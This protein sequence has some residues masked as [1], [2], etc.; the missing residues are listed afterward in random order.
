MNKLCFALFLFCQISLGQEITLNHNIGTNIIDQLNNFT[1][2]GGGVS[3]ARVFVLEEFGVTGEYTI[4][5]GSFAVQESGSA[6]G[7]GVIVNVYTIDKGFPDTFDESTI[8]GSS[9]LIDIPSFTN[10]AIFP[11]D[12]PVPIVV[13]NNVEM[14]L[15]EVRLGLQNQLVFMGGTMDSFDFSWWNPLNHQSCQGDP[16]T[17]ESTFDLSRPDL[18]YYITVTGDQILGIS[19]IEKFNLTIAPN[20]VE[21]YLKIKIPAEIKFD[22][23][24]IYDI[25]GQ[26]IYRNGFTRN[27]DVSKISSGLYFLEVTSPEGSVTRKFIKQ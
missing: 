15:V 3:W 25:N 27:I 24:V 23:L 4:T 18:N 14:I 5:S 6:P 26:I 7:D 9:E 13:P 1:C 16:N 20:P 10:N 8:I 22:Q 21:D 12:F 11:F 2:S 17:Y 19:D